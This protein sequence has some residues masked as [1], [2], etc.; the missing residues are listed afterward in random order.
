[1]NKSK[2]V[3]Y[4]NDGTYVVLWT[5]REKSLSIAAEALSELEH[6]D[7]LDL[8]INDLVKVESVEEDNNDGMS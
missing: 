7:D 1:M 4:F 5:K 8:G 6:Y 2:Y 3:A